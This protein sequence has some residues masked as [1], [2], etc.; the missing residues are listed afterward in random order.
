MRYSQPEA[1]NEKLEGMLPSFSEVALIT[2]KNSLRSSQR[3]SFLGRRC[4]R[5]VFVNYRHD[6]P[7]PRRVLIMKHRIT[8]LVLLFSFTLVAGLYG[9]ATTCVSN[10][11]FK[12]KKV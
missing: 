12:V 1:R 10:K 5:P 11:K 9:G 8:W 6:V 4:D 7:F 3:W 2:A